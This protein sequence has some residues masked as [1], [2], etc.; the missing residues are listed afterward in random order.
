LGALVGAAVVIKNLPN[1]RAAAPLAAAPKARN[2]EELQARAKTGERQAMLALLAVPEPTAPE[3]VALAEGALAR[4]DA[5]A[6]SKA[7]DRALSLDASLKERADVR[8]NLR[9]IARSA[10]A[11]EAVLRMAESSLGSHGPDL[12]FDVW[13]EARSS[14]QDVDL[15]KRTFSALNAAGLRAQ[16]SP[17]L[18]LAVDLWNARTCRDFEPLVQRAAE[19]ADRRS[20]PVLKSLLKTTG[21][22]FLKLEDCWSCLRRGDTLSRALT[23]AA[24]TPAPT[25]E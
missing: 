20:E 13:N 14:T 18:V 1:P 10:E 4:G 22:G 19:I 16:A 15:A 17:G 11:R 7:Y 24:T 3:L 2:T 23:R 21:C 8:R 12:V 5:V 25:F 9:R 6:A